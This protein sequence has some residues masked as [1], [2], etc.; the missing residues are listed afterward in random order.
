MIK[1][2]NKGRSLDNDPPILMIERL[3]AEQRRK[4]RAPSTGVIW[5]ASSGPLCILQLGICENRRNGKDLGFESTDSGS[6]RLMLC[7]RQSI[8]V[9]TARFTTYMLGRSREMHSQCLTG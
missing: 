7:V 4:E 2:C 5:R 6:I 9:V 8:N 1:N 3:R